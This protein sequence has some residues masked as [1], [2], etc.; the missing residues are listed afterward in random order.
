MLHLH[1]LMVSQFGCSRIFKI[2][3]SA[4]LDRP[5]ETL[6]IEMEMKVWLH[7]SAVHT[8]YCSIYY[9]NMQDKYANMQDIY[10]NM[11]DKN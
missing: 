6:I 1:V 9:V 3:V 4:F 8:S 2:P 5:F 7:I 11:Q 10:V